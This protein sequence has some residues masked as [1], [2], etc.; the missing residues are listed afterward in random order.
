MEK[1]YYSPQGFWRGKSAINKLASS[2]HVSKET[3]KTFL[4]KQAIWQIYLPAPKYT[5][6]AKFDIPYPNNTHQADLLFLPHDKVRRTTFKYAL[7]IV[8]VASRYKEAEPLKT[9]ESKEVASALERIYKRSPLTWPKVLQV[10]PGREFMG[11]V[12][13]LLQ[14]HDVKIRR[15]TKDAHRSQAIDERFNRT[16]SERLF[17]YQYSEEMKLTTGRSTEWVVRLP[18]VIAALNN[19]VT[20]LISKKPIDA[21]KL[22][23]VPSEPAAPIKT[24]KQKIS[25]DVKV[26]YLYAPG[27]LEGGNRRRATDP[28]WS[29]KTFDINRIVTKIGDP[30][31]YYLRD[32]PGRS[33]VRQE[34]QIIPHDTVLPPTH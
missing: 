23:Y 10:D 17:G 5:P 7:T 31:L 2:A 24:T 20:R 33:F 9:K 16:L 28:I 18:S 8:D 26:R 21:I 29:I 25:D 13:Q 30:I 27:E 32:G 6:R 11:S 15:G 22:K 1:I 4:K 3:A 34:L 14:K 12:N 19:E